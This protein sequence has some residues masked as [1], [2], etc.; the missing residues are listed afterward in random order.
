M[1]DV[2]KIGDIV[3]LA[4]GGPKMT[5]TLRVDGKGDEAVPLCR[6]MY[7]ADNRIGEVMVPEAALRLDGTEA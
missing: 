2:L 1:S 6:C 7:W 5:V 3:T 4:S